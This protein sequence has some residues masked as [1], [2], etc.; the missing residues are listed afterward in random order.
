MV[1]ILKVSRAQDKSKT[2]DVEKTLRQDRTNDRFSKSNSDADAEQPKFYGK[3][4]KQRNEETSEYASGG[5]STSR[6][7]AKLRF[8]S[9]R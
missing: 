2:F 5:N 6:K 1:L 3:C 4:R 7:S 8:L 9:R